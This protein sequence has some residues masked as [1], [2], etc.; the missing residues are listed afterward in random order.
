MLF[1]AFGR[2][3]GPAADT[4]GSQWDPQRILVGPTT[5]CFGWTAHAVVRYVW[6]EGDRNITHLKYPSHR[7]ISVLCRRV[8]GGSPNRSVASVALWSVTWGH[9]CE[10]YKKHTPWNLIHRCHAKRPASHLAIA[11]L[12]LPELLPTMAA[13]QNMT[14]AIMEPE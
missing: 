3:A 14:R 13:S 2:E 1:F 6:I 9:A 5:S 10:W 7:R 11:S 8:V 12:F 4:R